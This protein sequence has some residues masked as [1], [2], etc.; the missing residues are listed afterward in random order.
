VTVTGES[1]KSASDEIPSQDV[2]M[3]VLTRWIGEALRIGKD[4]Q[5][6]VVGVRGQQARIDIRAPKSIRVKGQSP[7]KRPD[8]N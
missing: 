6:V 3:L 4:I 5:V 7:S 1:V 8:K 2:R